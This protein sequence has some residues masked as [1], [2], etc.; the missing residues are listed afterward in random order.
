MFELLFNFLPLSFEDSNPL[1]QSKLHIL[2][3]KKNFIALTKFFL[4]GENKRP[5]FN[6]TFY[7][8]NCSK[9]AKCFQKTLTTWFNTFFAKMDYFCL[10]D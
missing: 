1:A 3:S 4:N 5:D 2:D 8:K 7:I 9:L 10:H 6:T